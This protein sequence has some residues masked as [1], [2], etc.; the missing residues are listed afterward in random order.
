MVSSEVFSSC[1]S[2]ASAS[3]ETRVTTSCAGVSPKLLGPC[4]ASALADRSQDSVLFS[5]GP[6]FSP[7]LAAREKNRSDSASKV[8]P[9]SASAKAWLALP[10]KELDSVAKAAVAPS[11]MA[12]ALDTNARILGEKVR[13]ECTQGAGFSAESLEPK[14]LRILEP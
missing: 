10:R 11:N 13:A 8:F 6:L 2:V 14:W 9:P 3:S 5:M 12:K 7:S 1:A 4:I